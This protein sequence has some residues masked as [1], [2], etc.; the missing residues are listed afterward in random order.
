M[1]SLISRRVPQTN[2]DHP[3]KISRHMFGSNSVCMKG[4]CHELTQSVYYKEY[5]CTG[6]HKEHQCP[7]QLMV[8]RRIR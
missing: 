5:I 2:I 1:K 7:N 8:L 6:V 3:M 4:L